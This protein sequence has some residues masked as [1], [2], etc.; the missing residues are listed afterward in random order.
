MP[1]TKSDGMWTSLQDTSQCSTLPEGALA[2]DPLGQHASALL[3][4]T[5]SAGAAVGGTTPHRMLRYAAPKTG[6]A[7]RQSVCRSFRQRVR[8]NNA[9]P[10]TTLARH[11]RCAVLNQATRHWHSEALV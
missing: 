7:R 10:H 1:T 9:F 3:S 5:S 8:Q 11:V 4:R 6:T 2:Q